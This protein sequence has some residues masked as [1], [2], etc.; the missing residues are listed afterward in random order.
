[1]QKVVQPLEFFELTSLPM[2]IGKFAA[3]INATIESLEN[4]E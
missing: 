3:S 4:Y 1:M 2:V